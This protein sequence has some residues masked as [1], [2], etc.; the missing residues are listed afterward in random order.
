MYAAGSNRPH[1][2]NQF[3]TSPAFACISAEVHMKDE[4]D[5]VK[6]KG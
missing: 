6:G 2:K 4:Q 3:S 1:Y 5:Y